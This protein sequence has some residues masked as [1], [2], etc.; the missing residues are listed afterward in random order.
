MPPVTSLR[1]LA[2][3]GRHSVWSK[4]NCSPPR[5]RPRRTSQNSVILLSIRHLADVR[6]CIKDLEM[7]RLS[8]EKRWAQCNHWV[9]RRGRQEGQSQ[10]RRCNNRSKGQNGARPRTKECRQPLGAAK[11]K[12]SLNSSSFH[13]HTLAASSPSVWG[14][15][16]H[17]E[18]VLL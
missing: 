2:L 5:R 8:A 11:G 7:G 14:L 12:K 15:W 4:N 10:R 1:L 6:D 3:L 17:P 13:S 9:L 18:S 16:Y